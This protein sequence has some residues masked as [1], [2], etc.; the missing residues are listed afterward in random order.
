MQTSTDVAEHPDALEASGTRLKAFECGE[1]QCC[2]VVS[3]SF[4]KTERF[5]D[6]LGRLSRLAQLTIGDSE[7]Q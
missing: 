1:V 2:P 5:W 4:P 7:T 6:G 3:G